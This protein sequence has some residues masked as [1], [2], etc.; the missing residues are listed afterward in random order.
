MEKQLQA[1]SIRIGV[2]EE[3][4][5]RLRSALAKVKAAA[6]Q[7]VLKVRPHSRQGELGATRERGAHASGVLHTLRP[8]RV[9]WHCCTSS[10]DWFPCREGSGEQKAVGLLT[11]CSLRVS[12]CS[13]SLRRAE[14][15][16]LGSSATGRSVWFNWCWQGKLLGQG[17][18]GWLPAPLHQPRCG[19]CATYATATSSA[20]KA[21]NGR[22]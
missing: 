21:T 9:P 1:N 10:G 22:D 4:N 6:E 5:A 12:S 14:L 18:Q 7:G 17:A 11:Q 8:P 2:L 13:P 19:C 15:Q 3:E 20:V 16:G